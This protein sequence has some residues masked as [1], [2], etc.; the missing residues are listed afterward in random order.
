MY[1]A[2]CSSSHVVLG[3]H[4]GFSEL[5][6]TVSFRLLSC[7]RLDIISIPPFLV[8]SLFSVCNRVSGCLDLCLHVHV[9][10]FVWTPVADVGCLSTIT[11]HLY[12]PLFFATAS[13]WSWISS[14][15]GPMSFGDPL[16]AYLLCLSLQVFM[17]M[18]V[19]IIFFM[20]VLLSQTQILMFVQQV[21]YILSCFSISPC[22]YFKK[23]IK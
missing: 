5:C 14:T 18:H 20:C 16:V 2:V 1:I 3:Q 21:A 12:S 4:T 15:D 11:F 9:S 23:E 10:V 17:A 7:L 13:H 6:K 22:L 8:S 19:I